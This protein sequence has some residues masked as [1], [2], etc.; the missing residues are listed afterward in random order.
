MARIKLD[1]PKKFHFTT[2]VDVRISDINYGNHMGNDALLSII[3]EARI[4]F[5][6]NFG[7]EELNMFGVSLIMS[8]V[9]IQYKNEAYYGDTLQIEITAFDFSVTSFDLFYFITR[10]PDQKVIAMAKTNMVCYNYNEKKMKDVPDQ[11][12][13][14]FQ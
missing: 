5:L 9:A 10:K 2:E 6:K 11:F 8:D 7:C 4:R 13:N 14:L 3:H 1:V 12:V